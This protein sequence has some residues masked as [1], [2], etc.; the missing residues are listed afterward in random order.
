MKPEGGVLMVPGLGTF[1]S[2]F[3]TSWLEIFAVEQVD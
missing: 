3:L 2:S 1:C